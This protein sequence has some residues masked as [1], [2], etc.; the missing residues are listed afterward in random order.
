LSTQ[1]S[2]EGNN[3]YCFKFNI[4]YDLKIKKNSLESEIKSLE[5]EIKSLESEI[6]SLE[7]EIKT[8]I[9]S[10][11]SDSD[12]LIN[13]KKKKILNTKIQENNKKLNIFKNQKD[14]LRLEFEIREIQNNEEESTKQKY[15][16]YLNEIENI[17]KKFK[18]FEIL[19]NFNDSFFK[20]F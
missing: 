8:E 1:N 18:I 5:S 12:N 6:K 11:E 4:G 16:E 9:K 10:L 17:E 2:Q 13:L 15:C 20:F 19:V 3:L 7:S 14:I